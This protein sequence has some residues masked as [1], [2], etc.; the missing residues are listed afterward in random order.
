MKRREFIS[1]L[2][3][4]AVG[5]PVA[6]NAQQAATYGVLPLMWPALSVGRLVNYFSVAANVRSI[7]STLR[8]SARS[9]PAK[10]PRTFTFSNSASFSA[11]VPCMSRSSASARLFFFGLGCFRFRNIATSHFNYLGVLVVARFCGLTKVIRSQPRKFGPGCA[12][13]AHEC[14]NDHELRQGG[15]AGSIRRAGPRKGQIEDG[16]N[17]QPSRQL[18][19]LP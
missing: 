13:R 11:A 6:A 19:E 4:A 3:G 17:P 1:L 7:R 15:G 5:W 14:W 18:G 8:S 16:V 10:P 9:S 12:R 2:S